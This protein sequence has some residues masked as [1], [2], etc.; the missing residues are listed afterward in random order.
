LETAESRHIY[1]VERD[2]VVER[3]SMNLLHPG[4]VLSSIIYGLRLFESGSVQS[5]IKMLD[6]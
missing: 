2:K 3:F 1:I 4:V 6:E 5:K